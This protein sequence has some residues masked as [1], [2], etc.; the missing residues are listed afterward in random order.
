MKYQTRLFSWWLFLL[1]TLLGAQGE[2]LTAKEVALESRF[3]S[4]LGEKVLGNYEKAEQQLSKLLQ[5]NP[6][7][8]TIAWELARVYHA[9]SEPE[10]ALQFAAQAWSIEKNPWF[11][12]FM[13]D[14]F[15][16]NQQPAK[17][18]AI[19][20][21]LIENQPENDY[22]YQKAGYY[23]VASQQLTEAIKIYDEL[24]KRI[25]QTEELSR[26]KYNLYLSLGKD[27]KAEQEL[28]RLIDNNPKQIDYHFQLALFYEESNKAD[29]ATAVYKKILAIDPTNGKAKMRMEEM[30][31]I[32]EKNAFT[33]IRY[34]FND[35]DVSV[36]EKIKTILPLVES[37][38]NNPDS[39]TL[40]ELKSLTNILL[41]QYPQ[42]A[43]PHALAGDLHQMDKQTEDAINA[44]QK[45]IALDKNVFSI[46][47]QM[48]YLCL[49][50]G[51][52]NR[53]IKEAENAFLLFPNSAD[54]FLLSAMAH[55][56]SG[57][58]NEAL[59]LLEQADFMS[60]FS[61]DL[62]AKVLAWKGAALNKSGKT[63]EADKAFDAALRESNRQNP[64][65]LCQIAIQL[66]LQNRNLE[67]A[68]SLMKEAE[69][70][71]Q[72][73][74]PNMLQARS[75]LAY[76]QGKTAEALALIEKAI[77][78]LASPT[79]E[80]IESYGDMLLEDGQANEAII[81][82][83]KALNMDYKSDSLARKLQKLK[84]DQ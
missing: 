44:Y 30:G 2:I 55:Y 42:N 75:L 77:L 11:G 71:L 18:A 22:N 52:Y 14:L 28:L 67:K 76:R 78:Q 57:N 51:Q 12:H 19:F 59:S 62:H 48:L 58:Y 38:S 70:K 61:P 53:A 66:A 82:W 36:D 41:N 1:P 68:T 4:A 80:M 46:R 39:N 79:P 9:V 6:N 56:Y 33:P 81:Q 5:E 16:Q 84:N 24:E 35:P 73:E 31:N 15:E 54:L 23:L 13:A 45:A 8:A 27:K 50:T 83:E 65:I 43:R 34:L 49:E 21:E 47:E 3:V 64:F 17:A 7:N 69:G 74:T 32:E 40:V 72:K 20:L 25:G 26:K 10:K 63:A 37:L 60:S 29:Q